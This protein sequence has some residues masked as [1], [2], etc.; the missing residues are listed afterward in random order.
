MFPQQLVAVLE[1][2]LGGLAGPTI[3]QSTLIRRALTVPHL[4]GSCHIEREWHIKIA[5]HLVRWDADVGEFCLW[6]YLVAL[7]IAHL[8]DPFS[9]D[10]AH[11]EPPNFIRSSGRCHP[12]QTSRPVIGQR[13]DR[14]ARSLQVFFLERTG[15]PD[16][17]EPGVLS[18]IS[19]I[20]LE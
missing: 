12:N 7:F 17:L 13:I 14:N 3:Y 19:R 1:E 18:N 2:I 20:G 15:G 5:P 6:F 9:T 4:N 10:A 16:Q 11:L 8:R